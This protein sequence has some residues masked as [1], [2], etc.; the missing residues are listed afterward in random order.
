ME[1]CVYLEM[2][3]VC[4]KKVLRHGRKAPSQLTVIGER[5]VLVR[6]QCLHMYIFLMVKE[7]L[8]LNGE[9]LF[10]CVL[11]VHKCLFVIRTVHCGVQFNDFVLCAS[12]VIA[13]LC[14]LF[15]DAVCVFRFLVLPYLV[16][17]WNCILIE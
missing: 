12:C 10:V 16:I 8:H 6:V 4:S 9:S 5:N 14:V 2:F 17:E 15:F 7:C 1:I 11:C 13:C 3:M